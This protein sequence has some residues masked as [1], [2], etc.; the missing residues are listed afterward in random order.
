MTEDKLQA[1]LSNIRECY[2]EYPTKPI[3]PDEAM[4]RQHIYYLL[5]VIDAM[6]RTQK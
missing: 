6:T 1:E 2:F 4:A 5:G 3:K